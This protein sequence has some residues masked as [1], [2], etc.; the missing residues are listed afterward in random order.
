MNEGEGMMSRVVQLFKE[1]GADP[2]VLLP[3][4]ERARRQSAINALVV[5]D[6]RL[7]ANDLLYADGI[8]SDEYIELLADGLEI[9]AK[10]T[11]RTPIERDRIRAA[12]REVRKLLEQR[13]PSSGPRRLLT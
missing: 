10:R 1:L 9:A 11:A 2:T 3:A 5:I 12:E 13:E 8:G 7:A 4:E 6:W